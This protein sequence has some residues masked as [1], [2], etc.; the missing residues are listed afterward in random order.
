MWVTVCVCV[1]R[2]LCEAVGAAVCACDIM[3]VRMCGS[4]LLSGVWLTCIWA[5]GNKRSRGRGGQRDCVRQSWGS[6]WSGGK[7]VDGFEVAWGQETG[8]PFRPFPLWHSRDLPLSGVLLHSGHFQSELLS[9]LLLPEYFFFSR[10]CFM[11][12]QRCHIYTYMLRC[13][14]K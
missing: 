12:D 11:E 5:W 9:F 7:W 2:N 6:V 1:H 3:C 13:V 4:V 10:W 14:A 8:V